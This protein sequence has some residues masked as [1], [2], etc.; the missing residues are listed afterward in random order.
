[1]A[2]TQSKKSSR[3]R[4]KVSMT[5]VK[6][7]QETYIIPSLIKSIIIDRSYY[8]RNMPI[9][10]M[11]LNL[12]A[13]EYNKFVS[14]RFNS[15]V[16]LHIERYDVNSDSAIT[17]DIIKDTFTYFLPD[18]NPNYT[19]SMDQEGDTQ[20]NAYKTLTIGLLSTKLIDQNRKVFNKVYKS[21]NMATLIQLGIENIPKVIMEPI[22]NNRQISAIHVPPISSISKFIAFLDSYCNLYSGGYS[23]FMDFDYTY[24]LSNDGKI[25]DIEDGTYN[26][27]SIDIQNTIA[28][29]S[30]LIGMITDNKEK[31]Y[32]IYV[33]ALSTTLSI[34]EQTDYI[35]NK[36][37]AV[38][39]SGITREG[40]I[41]IMG[42]NKSKK[43]MFER[44][45]NENSSAMNSIDHDPG[46]IIG[47]S[48][49]ELDSGV[50]QPNKE[51]IISN[52]EDNEEYNGN[53]YMIY[54]KDI[55]LQQDGE[56]TCNTSIGL[57]MV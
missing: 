29:E 19:K 24:L 44:V 33:D 18:S 3:Y 50:L 57:S 41:D 7:T 52:F 20:D 11:I 2:D 56:F 42:S 49:P 17:K 45:P 22:K 30:K 1:M 53:Y 32:K 40:D 54:K 37:M 31:I 12:N 6:G 8:I 26:T 13:E 39:T 23:F 51:W 48:K 38:T 21:T 27:I 43:M 36:F 34:D 25:I 16:V 47:I 5:H 9:I 14:G 46:I 28:D 35:M 10:I 4:Y 15:Q 55:L